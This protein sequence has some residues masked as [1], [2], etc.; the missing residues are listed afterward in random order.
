MIR[1]KTIK[2]NMDKQDERELWERLQKLPHGEFSE[3]TKEF[4]TDELN[5]TWKI[6]IEIG[7][8]VDEDGLEYLF[9]DIREKMRK[10]KEENNGGDGILQQAN[11]T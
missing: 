3:R 8:D 9:N 5:E 2:F 6:K 4:W 7:R 1:N 11:D 10:Q